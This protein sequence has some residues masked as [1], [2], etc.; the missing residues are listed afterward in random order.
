M[1]PEASILHAEN[2]SAGLAEAR[3]QAEIASAGP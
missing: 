3:K 2:S 1:R